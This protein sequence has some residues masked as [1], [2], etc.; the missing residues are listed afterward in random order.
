MRA[1]IIVI[2]L[3]SRWNL[4]AQYAEPKLYGTETQFGYT[5][6]QD[7]AFSQASKT[8]VSARIRFADACRQYLELSTAVTAIQTELSPWQ[9]S[10]QNI[11][12]ITPEMI[13][14]TPE[15]RT[16][17]AIGIRNSQYVPGVLLYPMGSGNFQMSFSSIGNLL[18][19][20]EDVSPR[21]VYSVPEPCEVRITIYSPSALQVRTL[22]QGTQHTGT[23]TID[24]DG[25][26]NAGRYAGRGDYIAEIHVGSFYIIRKRIS[27]P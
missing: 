12:A 23:Y 24:W 10:M 17:H 8:T 6:A 11:A 15:E 27:L 18:G 3:V 25:K 7:S 4:Y 5:T 21:L 14:P 19:L 13:A 16:Q 1:L 26:N 22:F 9:Q 20:T 2:L